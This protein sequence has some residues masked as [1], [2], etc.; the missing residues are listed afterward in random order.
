MSYC[1][2]VSQPGGGVMRWLCLA[3]IVLTAG[4]ASGPNYLEVA[5]YTHQPSTNTARLAVYRSAGDMYPMRSPSVDVNGLPTC[6][7][8]SGGIFIKDVPPGRITISSSLWDAPGTS[9]LNFNA[10]AGRTYHVRMA[11]DFGKSFGALAGLP[12]MLA[13]EAISDRGGPFTIG[14]VEPANVQ[15]ELAELKVVSCR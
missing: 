3:V 7:L 9:R 5:G 2:C 14:I 13:A 10:I 8:P 11:V 12:G 1:P 6:D 4:C 15:N